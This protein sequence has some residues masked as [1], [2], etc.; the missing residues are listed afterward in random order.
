M[1]YLFF[2]LQ[3]CCT[4]TEFKHNNFNPDNNIEVLTNEEIDLL[5]L[6]NQYRVENKL[7]RL[8]VDAIFHQVA[9]QRT[10]TMISENNISHAGFA[11][12]IQPIVQI[13]LSAG[14]NIAYGYNSN[15]SVLR[16]WI[17]SEKHRQNILKETWLY[18][19][20]SL[21]EDDNGRKYYCQ[22]FVK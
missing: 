12:A 14:E 1:M 11:L 6:L 15:E 18:T 9:L 13:G 4:P 22:I 21:Q 10:T 8:K 20:I 19:G 17:S 2:V 5:E 16:A 3:L 7:E